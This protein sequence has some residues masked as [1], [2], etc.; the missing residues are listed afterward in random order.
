VSFF[1]SGVQLKI[2]SL[3]SS[4]SGA[5]I[6]FAN[7]TGPGL[8]G[9]VGCN[10]AST[11]TSSPCG[12][13]LARNGTNGSLDILDT[14]P[15]AAPSS[16]P[17]NVSGT[18]EF[19]WS[20]AT[21]PGVS[22][23]PPS[24]TGYWISGGKPI[25]ITTLPASATSYQ[26][27]LYNSTGSVLGTYTVTNPNWPA[28][29]TLGQQAFN[30]N[31]FPA[32]GQDVDTNFLS[33][34][35]SQAGLVTSTTVDFTPPPTTSPLTVTGVAVQSWDKSNNCDVNPGTSLAPGTTSV[36][37]SAS[38]TCTNGTSEAFWAIN[39]A[40]DPAFRLVQLQSRNSLGVL[41]YWNETVRSAANAPS[42]E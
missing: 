9:G 24:S 33:A 7:V 26:F 11:S 12:V 2:G 39:N 42:A 25:D 29:A 6:S 23:T 13:W 1:D 17:S 40:A 34:S 5:N 14:P 10:P 8:P 4:G 32:L 31:Y 35:G 16:A 15:S 37:V 18:A 36:T 30:N 20:W 38:G 22:F 21:Q 3:G 27:T 41:F 19:R 28:D